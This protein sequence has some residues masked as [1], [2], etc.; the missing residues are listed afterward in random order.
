MVQSTKSFVAFD[1]VFEER[2]SAPKYQIVFIAFLNVQFAVCLNPVINF[3][4]DFY[5]PPDLY[6]FAQTQQY[7]NQSA[8]P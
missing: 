4:S 8:S 3:R 6:R 7:N 1:L 2:C 5:I